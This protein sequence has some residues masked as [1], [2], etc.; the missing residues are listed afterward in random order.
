MLL[1]KGTDS[2]FSLL[3]VFICVLLIIGLAYFFTKYVVGRGKLG[4]I[5]SGRRD[6]IKVAARV[7]VGRDSQLLLVQIGERYFLLGSTA[8]GITKLAEFTPEEAELWKNVESPSAGDQPPS[9]G[10]A[11]RKAWKQRVKR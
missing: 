10:E 7:S 11:I 4:M 9:F 8:S 1:T 2:L 5:A 3:W 6:I